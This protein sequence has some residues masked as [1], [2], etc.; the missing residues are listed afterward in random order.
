MAQAKSFKPFYNWN[1][2]NT[3]EH[4]RETKFQIKF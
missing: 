3:S 1:T 4:Y 2:F